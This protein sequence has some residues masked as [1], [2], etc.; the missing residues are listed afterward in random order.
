MASGSHIGRH[1]ILCLQLLPILIILN[2]ISED[3]LHIFVLA[4]QIPYKTFSPW[5]FHRTLILT[6]QNLTHF[7]TPSLFFLCLGKSSH[8]LVSFLSQILNIGD[9]PSNFLKQKIYQNPFI[10]S[11]NSFLKSYLCYAFLQSLPWFSSSKYLAR[12]FLQN[13]PNLSPSS[14]LYSYSDNLLSWSITPSWCIFWNTDRSC[15]V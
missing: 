10:L 1:R 12:N 15:L 14:Q 13:S 5:S 11:T 3:P 2:S 7:I 6:F 8:W 4:Y 9:C